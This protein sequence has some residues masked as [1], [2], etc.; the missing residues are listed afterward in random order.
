MNDQN[1]TTADQAQA[2][3]PQAD[4]NGGAQAEGGDGGPVAERVTSL[5]LPW[6]RAVN[7]RKA[8]R[9]IGS[10]EGVVEGSPEW[11]TVLWAEESLATQGIPTEL[12]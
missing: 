3:V 6:H 11:E 4:G 1:E 12:K 5:A 2:A 9:A 7:L 8:L 10:K